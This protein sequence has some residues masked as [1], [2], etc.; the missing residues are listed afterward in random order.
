M[1]EETVHGSL[2][3][4]SPQL[5]SSLKDNV[6]AI[7]RSIEWVLGVLIPLNAALIKSVTQFNPGVAVRYQ[8]RAAMKDSVKRSIL[9]IKESALK[10]QK[11]LKAIWDSL[12]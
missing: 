11:T 1:S 9:K 12:V 4:P 6:S 7:L 3:F 2:P 10:K 5:V 8:C